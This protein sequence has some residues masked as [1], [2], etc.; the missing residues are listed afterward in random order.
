M[1]RQP[2]YRR[3]LRIGLAG[4]VAGWLVA[5]AVLVQCAVSAGAA[6]EMWTD[7]QGAVGMAHA[8]CAAHGKSDHH[9][10]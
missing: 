4:R 10:G 3:P 8:H 1:R 5:F 6:L 2:S 9:S 7:A